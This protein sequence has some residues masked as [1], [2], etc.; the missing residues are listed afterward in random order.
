[1]ISTVYPRAIV[2]PGSPSI[3]YHSSFGNSLATLRFDVEVRTVAADPV[4]A[5]RALAVFADTAVTTSVIDALE[6]VDSPAV[7]PTL[8]GAVENVMVESVSLPPGVQLTEGGL[9]FT[10]LFSVIVLARRT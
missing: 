2:M 10:A 9:E 7:T 4:V 5:Q 8:G 3:E 1:M 6:R